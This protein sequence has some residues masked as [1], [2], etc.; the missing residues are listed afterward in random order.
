MGHFGH[1]PPPLTHHGSAA[2]SFS[3]FSY[4]A[5]RPG[6]TTPG[7]EGK[8]EGGRANVFVGG[9]KKNQTIQEACRAHGHIEV[10]PDESVDKCVG[11]SYQE[12]AEAT[13]GSP[14]PGPFPPH[15]IL[16][17][18]TAWRSLLSSEHW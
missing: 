17:T 16:S 2:A 18:T 8:R 12:G 10:V 1:M 4:R 14:F 6:C 3:H 9:E 7:R 11:C 5:S 15:D 13:A